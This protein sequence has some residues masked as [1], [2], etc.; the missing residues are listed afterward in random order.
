MEQHGKVRR[1]DWWIIA[2]TLLIVC[3]WWIAPGALRAYQRHR[4]ESSLRQ[5]LRA[6]EPPPKTQALGVQII[7]VGRH[8]GLV[9]VYSSESDG[10]SIKSHYM[11]EF[12]RHGFAYQKARDANSTSTAFN[13]CAPGYR[14][15]LSPMNI[16]VGQ[17]LY[18]V[19]MSRDNT[20]C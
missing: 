19:S 8:V 18:F 10:E 12:A 1:W 17:Q 9:A 5:V 13:F 16:D 20:P 4:E 2:V 3:A 14:A 7:P 11:E 6:I 15:S